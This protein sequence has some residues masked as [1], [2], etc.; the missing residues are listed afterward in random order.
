MHQ[1]LKLSLA[2]IVD[3]E[4]VIAST[5]ELILARQGFDAR[6]FVDPLDAL[7]AAQFIS[8]DL[9]LTDV[10]MPQMNGIE[11]AI[12]IK[13]RCPN[14]RILLSSGQ[15][16]VANELLVEAGLHGHHFEILPKPVHPK[17]LLETIERL[18]DA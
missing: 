3:D 7:N 10:V 14:C 8:P 16:L 12:K 4:K 9:L 1:I 17:V 13:Q 5:L 11:L 15:Q 18:F 6:F 2:F